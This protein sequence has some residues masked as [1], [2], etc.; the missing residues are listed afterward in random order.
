MP[1]SISMYSVFTDILTPEDCDK[2]I[3]EHTSPDAEKNTPG[4]GNEVIGTA[5]VDLEV[6]NTLITPLAPYRG[7]GGVLA[8]VGLSANFHHWKFDV[9]HSNQAEFLTYPAGGRYQAH[10]DVAMISDVACRKLTV[11]AFLND[12]FTGGK[13]YIQDGHEKCYPPQSKGTVLVFPSFYL[14]GVEDIEE[15]IRYSAVCWMAGP[16]FK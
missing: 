8:G 16:F 7:L 9:T 6:R 11:I 10:I 14:H 15:S 5:T 12:G 13:F 3:A 2:Y 1:E 4:I